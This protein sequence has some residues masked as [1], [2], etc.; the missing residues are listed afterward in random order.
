M[1]SDMGLLTVS[2]QFFY[3][4]AIYDADDN[5]GI[6]ASR[7]PGYSLVKARLDWSD[8]GGSKWNAALFAKNLTDKVYSIGGVSVILPST[9]IA[10]YFYGDPRTFGIEIRRDF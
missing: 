10:T 4:S 8:V 1:P 7:H 5:I 2:G 3:N 6:P 9:G